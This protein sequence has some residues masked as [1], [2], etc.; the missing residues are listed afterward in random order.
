MNKTYHSTSPENFAPAA[1]AIRA[2]NHE[3][4]RK[5]FDMVSTEETSV[6]EIQHALNLEQSVTSQHLAILRREGFVHFRREG[7]KILYTA[8]RTRFDAVNALCGRIANPLPESN[9]V[10]ANGG[11]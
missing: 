11:E 5:I 8:N 2:I 6:Q 7:K 9:A 1:Q 10:E 3:L 4:R